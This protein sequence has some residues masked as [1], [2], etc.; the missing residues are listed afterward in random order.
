MNEST[1]DPNLLIRAA[2][3][4]MYEQKARYYRDKAHDRR[5][6]GREKTDGMPPEVR[7]AVEA[8]PQPMAVYRFRDH[9]I[10]PLAVSDGFCLLFGYP[11]RE[12]ALHVLDQDI[13]KDIHH[14]DQER[15]SGAL[16]RFSEGTD[17]LD[18]VYRT[19]AGMDSGYRVIHARGIHL[20][21]ASEER[22]AEVW[23]MDE[24][25]YEDDGEAGSLMTQALSRALHEESIVNAYHYDELTGL[26]TPA[27][28][29]QLCGGQKAQVISEG[30][31]AALIYI[32]LNGMKYFNHKFGFTEGDNLLK[33]FAALMAEIFG[34]DSCCHIAADRFAAG[35]AEDETEAKSS[36]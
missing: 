25:V 31:Q 19:K 1:S 36:G 20:H 11:D 5:R 9:S 14:D 23:Y 18:V 13:Y 7:R 15:Y 6:K 32:D 17:E 16:L 8:S 26:P 27:W 2:E 3:M 21:T 10:E 4:K 35:S 24:G 33:A 12:K 29:F 30:K 28:F 34:K 22:I